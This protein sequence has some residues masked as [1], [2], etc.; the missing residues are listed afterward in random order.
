MDGGIVSNYIVH[1]AVLEGYDIIIVVTL[2]GYGKKELTE[3]DYSSLSGVLG[4]T[5]SVVLNNVSRGEVDL[6]DYWFSPDLTGYG[7]LS[8]ASAEGILER[9]R[10]EAEEQ[11]AKLEEIAARFTE[12]QK[13][14]KDPDRVGEY[15]TRYAEKSKKEFYS[16]KDLRHEDLL[17]RTRLS[18]GIYGAGGY[19]FFFKP[20]DDQ[21]TKRA[22]Y[23]TLS[24]RGFIKDIGG[25]PA[26]LDIRLKM[27]MNRT[28]D[29]SAMGLLSIFGDTLERLYGLVRI[30]GSIG[31]LTFYTDKSEPLRVNSIEKLVGFDAG[32]MLTNEYNHNIMLYGS[33]D[34]TWTGANE[35]IAEEDLGR[36]FVTSGTFETVFY[37]D[38]TAGFFSETGSR[39][40]AKGIVG[41]SSD[42]QS[43]FYKIALAAERTFKLNDK[44]SIWGDA[45]AVASRGKIALRSTFE[46]YG[47]WDG[48]PGYASGTLMAE[49]I[50]AGVGVQVNLSHSFASSYLS[51][52]VRGAIRS[53]V[54]YGWMYMDKE[55]G[56]MVPFK[57]CFD[58]GFWDLGVSVGY[59]F[60]TPVGDI[61][62]GAGFNKDLQLAL[63]LEL[64]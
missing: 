44:V 27:A 43:W 23:P 60:N 46:E 37:P 34:L 32:L 42:D 45:M 48:M 61:I 3:T 7:T 64:T 12:E 31:S 41:F 30:R 2:N 13:V 39:V 21:K 56:T 50:T 15:H 1:R 29:L 26:S 54:Q 24:L 28:T 36:A 35:T 10:R 25:S 63:Y 19:G 4:S 62:I 17:G 14:Y 53:D 33:A 5:L 47:G 58:K 9:G 38:Y 55:F 40:D 59:G 22:M 52:V 20:D 6:A 18:L 8:F 57:D 16:T 51:L 49:F 11:Q